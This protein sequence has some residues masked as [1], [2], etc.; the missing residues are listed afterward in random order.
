[1][2]KTIQ[3]KGDYIRE[4]APAAA[5]TL[6]GKPVVINSDG[7]FAIVATEGAEFGAVAIEDSLQGNTVTDAYTADNQLQANYQQKGNK[8]QMILKAG[9]N[10]AKG[11]RLIVAA[12]GLVIAEASADSGTVV[13]Q[14]VVAE[15]ALDLSASGAVDTL[16]A[17]R[18]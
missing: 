18:F 6:P 15:E 7:K 9:E 10:V 17:V 12:S 3:L 2:A 4:E 1:M 14:T 11:A 13:K 16:I 5:S 8:I